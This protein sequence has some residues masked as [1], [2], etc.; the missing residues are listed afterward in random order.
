MS[1]LHFSFNTFWPGL[2][3]A[4]FVGDIFLFLKF[5][6]EMLKKCEDIFIFCLQVVL[7]NP[8]LLSLIFHCIPWFF[9]YFGPISGFHILVLYGSVAFEFFIFLAN[10]RFFFLE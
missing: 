10:G 8:R 1:Y 6:D 3:F 9:F 4:A 7:L 5:E 2:P